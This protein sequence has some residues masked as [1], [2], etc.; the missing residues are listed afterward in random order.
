MYSLEFTI[1]G[2]P[3]I[4]TNGSHGHWT[5]KHKA[6]LTWAKLVTQAIGAKKPSAPLRVAQAEFVRVSSKEPDFDNL[7]SSFKGV[8]DSLIKCGIIEND[9]T[10]NLPNAIYRWEFVKRG[11]GHIKV[12]IKEVSA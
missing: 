11:Q 3:R 5:I 2:L 4:F 7:V 8:R 9:K 6:R 12:S 1:Q 10:S